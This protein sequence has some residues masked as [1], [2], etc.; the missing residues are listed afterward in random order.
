MESEGMDIII[1]NV[2]IDKLIFVETY[3][4]EEWLWLFK[5][6]HNHCWKDM[7]KFICVYYHCKKNSKMNIN[8]HQKK[9]CDKTMDY[10][11]NLLKLKLYPPLRN[12]TNGCVSC[13]RWKHFGI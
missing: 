8:E 2:K 10:E 6:C 11:G 9:G 4:H 1:I 3:T 5:E 12:T 7:K 13:E